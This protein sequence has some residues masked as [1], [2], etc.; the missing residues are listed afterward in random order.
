[1]LYF[2]HMSERKPPEVERKERE[3]S[4]IKQM[5]DE[6]L[7]L[8][9]KTNGL[10]RSVYQVLDKHG[11]NGSDRERLFRAILDEYARRRK[12][13]ADAKKLRELASGT[14]EKST[15][16]KLTSSSSDDDEEEIW[17]ELDRELKA[18]HERDAYAHQMK[19]P[20]SA[21]DPNHPENSP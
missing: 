19:Q 7:K 4:L 21:W 18:Q 3:L 20:A 15:K 11:F 13:K 10:P 2:P 14:T 9:T 16:K 8:I 5:A 12:A 17:K 1:M 6:G